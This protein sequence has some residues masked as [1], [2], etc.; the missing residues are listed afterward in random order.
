MPPPQI[1]PVEPRE[2]CDIGKE[3]DQLAELRY[4]QISSGRDYSYSHILEP[5]IVK[6]VTGQ[7]GSSAI[8]VGCGVGILTEELTKLRSRVVGIDVSEYS[9]SRARHH[10][11]LGDIG[12]FVVASVE[13]YAARTV[14]KFDTVIANMMLMSSPNLKSTVHAMDSLMSSN[15]HLIITLTH[16]WFWPKYWG[17]DKAP[18]FFYEDEI[19]MEAPFAITADG[20]TPFAITHIHRSLEQYVSCFIE[21]GLSLTC[22]IEPS[23]PADAPFEYRGN[24]RFPRFLAITCRKGLR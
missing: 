21:T 19:F 10:N 20:P 11:Q 15:G 5:T 3:W 23:A 16:P 17:Y 7:S 12:D 24:W 8:D 9:I 13:D 22:L 14:E 2:L 18:W 1:R 6:L 4:E